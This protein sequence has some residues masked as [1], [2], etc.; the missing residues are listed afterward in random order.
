V[1]S[2]AKRTTGPGGAAVER[3]ATKAGSSGGLRHL[4]HRERHASGVPGGQQNGFSLIGALSA[5]VRAAG[6]HLQFFQRF[7]PTARVFADFAIGDSMQTQ[8]N[9]A[10]Q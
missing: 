4:D 5:T 2:A 3:V 6:P 7:H 1:S 8:T 9:M 10:A